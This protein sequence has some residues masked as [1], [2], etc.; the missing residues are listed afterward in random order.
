MNFLLS[1]TNLLFPFLT[2]PYVSRI[3][4]SEGIGKV[5]F[6]TAVVSY[7]TLVAALG[8]PTYGIR[9]CAV[10]RED[11][12]QLSKTVQELI[13]IH[14]ISTLIICV[15][16]GVA[17]FTVP[18]FYESKELLL[19]IGSNII[20]N[21][22]GVNWLY[23]ALEQYT[24]IAMR[25]ICFKLLSIILMFIIIKKTEDVI[26]YGGL[27]VLASAG[28]NIMNFINMKK[29]IDIKFQ[30]DYD[31]KRHFKPIL[32]LFA[33]TMSITIYANL[34]TVMLGFIK[35][36]NQV[37]LYDA[38]VKMKMVC[39]QLVSSLG[40]VLLPRLSYLIKNEE[41]G[42]FYKLIVKSMEFVAIIS[43]PL[44]AYCMIFSQE[45]IIF[46]SGKSFLAAQAATKIISPTIILIGFSNI[47]GL[48][49]LTPMKKEVVV[50][51]SVFGGAVIDLI[52]NCLFIPKAGAAGAA[53][54]TLCAEAVVLLIQIIYLRQLIMPLFQQIQW[55]KI[56][57]ALA[58]SVGIVFLLK[59]FV[60]YIFL[61][62]F[63]MGILLFAIY[64]I[65]L[66]V[67]KEP[68]IYQYIIICLEK[69]K[70]KKK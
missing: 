3:L 13:I 62:L 7:F 50:L 54:G 5:S 65:L 48:Q 35:D 34:D 8:I 15:C 10:V 38:A 31:F 27:S 70:M 43:I 37:G 39:I 61:K 30:G 69:L 68:L 14:I 51:G 63:I 47:L 21:V 24:Y 41:W 55:H 64:G 12:R 44:T 19:I 20:L 52:L 26:L 18:K 11:R 32:I 59:D 66:F 58:V 33:Q 4:L 46:L 67:F 9:A 56:G 36:N 57:L 29:H 16:F 22:F 23:S 45:I 42:A 6:A 40:A 25:S 2:F 49:I 28:S 17:L 53:L 60:V 1:I